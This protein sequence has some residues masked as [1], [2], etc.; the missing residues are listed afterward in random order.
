MSVYSIV[1]PLPP[2]SFSSPPSSPNP[3]PDSSPLSS[4]DFYDT[5]RDHIDEDD[6]P[7]FSLPH[8]LAGNWYPPQYEK[9]RRVSLSPEPEDLS[10]KRLKPAPSD[11]SLNFSPVSPTFSRTRDQIELDKWSDAAAKVIDNTHGLVE[12]E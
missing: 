5:S 9:K 7:E 10:N 8:P 6:I 1:P 2:S 4:P 12:L 11:S 3:L